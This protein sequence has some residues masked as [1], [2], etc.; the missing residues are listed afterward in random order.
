MIAPPSRKIKSAER[1]IALFELFSREQQPFTVGHV[2][3]HLGVPQ[4]SISMLLRN[5]REMGYLEYDPV[6]RT[7]TPSVRVALL[8]SW[9]DQ[10]FGTAGA[11]GKRLSALHDRVGHTAYIGIQNGPSAQYVMTKAS[12]AP[13]R[14]DVSSGGYRS[15]TFSA[16]GRALLS[17]MPATEVVSWVRRCNAEAE[18]ERWRVRESEFL[19]MMRA[20]RAQGFAMTAGDVTP[21]M[22]AIAM[23][24]TSPMS[25]TPLAVGVGGAIARIKADQDAIVEALHAFVAG[26]TEA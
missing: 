23:T 25:R 10:R 5:L 18:S 16:M 7:F 15:L 20:I 6:S 21:G 3:R 2:A 8:G 17:L 22:S 19:E 14:L 13:D 11:L 1:T 26:N 24:F 9:I 12:R 4:P